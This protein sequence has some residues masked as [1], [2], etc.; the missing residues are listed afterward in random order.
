MLYHNRRTRYRLTE[1]RTL[2]LGRD[3]KFELGLNTL[4]YLVH[5]ALAGIFVL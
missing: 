2:S 3:V 4:V 1:K 5:T